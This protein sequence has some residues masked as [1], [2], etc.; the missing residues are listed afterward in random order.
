VVTL[1]GRDH[2]LGKWPVNKKTAPA[3]VKAAY[4][5]TISE[6]LARGRMPE[7]P[8]LPPANPLPVPVHDQPAGA[9]PDQAELPACLTVLEL[10]VRYLKHAE[11]YYRRQDGSNTNEL[12]E[13]RCSLRPLVHLYAT[14]PAHEFSPLKL[15]AVRELMVKGYTHPK[16]G[17]QKA[18]VRKL[19]NARVRRIVRVYKWAVSKELV[20][21]S[22]WQALTSLPGLQAGRCEARE[23]PP[24]EPVSI[25]TVNATLA[26][27][28]FHL[29]VA[30]R[31]QTLTG[32]RA[33]ELLALKG[34]SLDTSKPIWLSRPFHHKGSHRGKKRVIPIG[35]RGQ[36]ALR[37]LL[38]MRC[39]MCGTMERAGRIGWCWTAGLCGPCADRMDEQ[40]VCGPWPAAPLTKEEQ[41]YWIFSAVE[42]MADRSRQLRAQRKTKVQ[43]SQQDRRKKARKRAPQDRYTVSAYDQAIERAAQRA[44]VEHWSSHQLRHLA[45][46]QARQRFGLEAA[47]HLLGHEKADVTQLYAEKNLDLAIR[48][49]AE[50]G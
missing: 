31:L 47:Q 12:T 28:H 9:V 36:E 35:P 2:Y 21:E 18:L 20:P 8:P 7:P 34:D 42:A 13:M 15:E 14:L 45:G 4:D 40:D 6:W 22:T 32:C 17:P 3:A 10:S 46:T 50:I 26:Q 39:P 33:G 5:R 23:K 38:R 43:P 44:G 48:L 19:V 1:N 30:V 24:V 49:A 41:A 29:Q 37:P 11:Q 27:L 16:Y 25:E